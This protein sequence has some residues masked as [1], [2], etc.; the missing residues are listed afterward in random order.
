MRDTLKLIRKDDDDA[1]FCTAAAGGGKVKLSRIAWSVPIVQPNDMCKVNLYKS[2]ASNNA[3]L[4][5]FRI[6]QCVWRLGVSSASEKP[7]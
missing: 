4:V 7:Q 5:S 3:I 2:I 6:H 1:L